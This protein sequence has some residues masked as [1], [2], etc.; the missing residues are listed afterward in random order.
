MPAIAV[1]TPG[2]HERHGS[3]GR[4]GRGCPAEAGRCHSEGY[5]ER[6]PLSKALEDMG[7]CALRVPWEGTLCPGSPR[8]GMLCPGSPREGTPCPG[9]PPPPGGHAAFR[10]PLGGQ[11]TSAQAAGRG[12]GTAPVWNVHGTAWWGWSEVGAPGTWQPVRGLRFSS[13]GRAGGGAL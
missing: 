12:A 13:R 1:V 10:V 8:E 11:S 5:I 6:C 4:K 9:S 3:R 2:G 7:G